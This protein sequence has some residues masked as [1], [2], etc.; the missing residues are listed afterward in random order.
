M[1]VSDEITFTTRHKLVEELLQDGFVSADE[2]LRLRREM[3]RDGV[4]DMTEAAE[5]FTIADA[6]PDGDREWFQFFKEAMTDYFVRQKEPHGY[7]SEGDAAFLLDRLGAPEKL[8]DLKHEC[9][10]HMF[11]EAISV[12]KPLCDYALLTVR[13]HVL[14]DGKI[15]AEEVANLRRFLFAAGGDGG[16]NITRDEAELMFD[17]NDSCRDA[18]NA[19]EWTVLFKQVIANYLMAHFGWQ[20]ESRDRFLDMAAAP[21]QAKGFGV[22]FRGILDVVTGGLSKQKREA[23]EV[24]RM[25][26][27]RNAQNEMAAAQAAQLTPEETNWLVERLGRDGQIDQNEAEM[28]AHLEMIATDQGVE[29]P[30]VLRSLKDKAA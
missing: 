10:V 16:V 18:Q 12:P 7:I 13:A 11:H 17:L 14:A 19:P 9:L 25:Y 29:V 8:N 6:L 4:V 15:T 26:A 3:F 23:R 27:R 1:P 30:E 2:V 20:P 5:L 24:E 22:Y 21:Q 28:L